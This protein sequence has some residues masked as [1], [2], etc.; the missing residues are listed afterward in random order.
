MNF[1]FFIQVLLSLIFACFSIE[2][3]PEIIQYY[4]NLVKFHNNLPE[5]NLTL[6]AHSVESK[7]EMKMKIKKKLHK[8][9]PYVVFNDAELNE[10]MITILKVALPEIKRLNESNIH[11]VFERTLYLYVSTDVA[12]QKF[13]HHIKSIDMMFLNEIVYCDGPSLPHETFRWKNILIEKIIERNLSLPFAYANYLHLTDI[14]FPKAIAEDK[15]KLIFKQIPEIIQYIK[16]KPYN[17]SKKYFSYGAFEKYGDMLNVL[18]EINS[19]LYRNLHEYIITDIATEYYFDIFTYSH[20]FVPVSYLDR[21]SKDSSILMNN[22][23]KD[24]DIRTIAALYIKLNIDP[25]SSYFWS[26]TYKLSNLFSLK[27]FKKI[28]HNDKNGEQHLRNLILRVSKLQ[29]TKII[30]FYMFLLIVRSGFYNF[31]KSDTLI[32]E[33][34]DNNHLNYFWSII[35]QY[36]NSI[37]MFIPVPV[38]NGT[39]IN[40]MHIFQRD[41]GKPNYFELEKVGAY[42]ESLKIDDPLPLLFIH[43]RYLIPLQNNFVFDV[44]KFDH[45]KLYTVGDGDISKVIMDPAYKIN[46]KALQGKVL[47]FEELVEATGV[48]GLW[49]ILKLSADSTNLAKNNTEPVSLSRF[50][51]EGINYLSPN[52]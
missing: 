19:A 7:D 5:K 10:K 41:S 37:N 6:F 40:Y 25:V 8:F 23:E 28:I 49:D 21:M 17:L 36:S 50:L 46:F 44:K 14:E 34:Y 43:I 2:K 33:I 12:F 13:A 51:H 3:L 16:T 42:I 30:H 38:L 48:H 52:L 32:A 9:S 4:D 45:S 26:C 47:T 39:G 29:D 11:D 24:L 18:Y 22:V 35:C 27:E 31:Q 15:K 20:S 1:Q